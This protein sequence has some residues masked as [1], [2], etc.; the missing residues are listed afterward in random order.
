MKISLNLLHNLCNSLLH[1]C[2]VLM[3]NLQLSPITIVQMPTA[4]LLWT[5]KMSIFGGCIE[6]KSHFVL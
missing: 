3:A 2:F 1:K 4:Q 5:I 6:K